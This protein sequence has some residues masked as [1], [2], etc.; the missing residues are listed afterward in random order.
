MGG[1]EAFTP[2][3]SVGA[4]EY[5]FDLRSTERLQATFHRLR[6]ELRCRS[7]VCPAVRATVPYLFS[8]PRDRP[9]ECVLKISRSPQPLHARRGR[10]VALV[11][12]LTVFSALALPYAALASPGS[13]DPGFGSGGKVTTNL[14][15][16]DSVTV[17]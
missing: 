8:R 11:F 7:S 3:G 13:L 4:P 12:A 15:S 5:H 6:E 17:V 2:T 9:G 1:A 16:S 14:S 10:R